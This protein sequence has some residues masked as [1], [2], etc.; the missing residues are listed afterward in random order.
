[1]PARKLY[2]RYGFVLLPGYEDNEHV[3]MSH[4]LD[5]ED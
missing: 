5:L 1:M 2:E 4:K 3:V